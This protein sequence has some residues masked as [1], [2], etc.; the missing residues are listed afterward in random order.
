MPP[1]RTGLWLM[2][3]VIVA[4]AALLVLGAVAITIGQ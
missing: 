2:R 1:R 3:L 4:V